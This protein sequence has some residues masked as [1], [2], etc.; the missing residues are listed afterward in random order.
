MDN[1]SHIKIPEMK[2][3]DMQKEIELRM[4]CIKIRRLVRRNLFY[5]RANMEIVV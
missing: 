3:T 2:E 1:L 5:G 4:I